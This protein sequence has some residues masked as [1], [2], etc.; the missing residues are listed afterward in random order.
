VGE[1]L[2]PTGSV[3]LLPLLAGLVLAALPQ[4]RVAVW[5]NLAA[6]TAT[7]ALACRLPWQLGARPLL[8]VDP[9]AA[10]MAILASFVGTTSAWSMAVEADAGDM[11]LRH[12]LFQVLLALTLL[13][14]LCN[15][16]GDIWICLE[17]ALLIAVVTVAM[18][19]TGEAVAAAWRYLLVGAVG[20]ALAMFGSVALYLAA[21]PAL[22]TWSSLAQTGAG[23]DVGLLN[24]AFVLLV[25]GFGA[26]AGLAP[27]HGWVPE[28]TAAG[29]APIATVFTA[30]MQL[31]PLLVVFRL[32]RVVAA[33]AEA[34]APGPLLLVLGLASLLV[35]AIGVWR[36]REA[37]RVF[38]FAG[39]A[40]SGVTLFAIGLGSAAAVFA[41]IVLLTLQT[42]TRPT[43]FPCAQH[44]RGRRL[45]LLAA[46]TA[47]AG[48]PPFGIFAGWF[49]VLNATAGTKP[50][51][52]L[53]LGAG[54]VLFA[55]ALVARLVALF[56]SAPRAERDGK[57]IVVLAPVWLQLVAGT[58]LGYAMPASLAAWFAAVASALR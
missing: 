8:L 44:L 51:L 9:P 21:R 11:R 3:V 37:K 41:G 14:L 47:M 1:F 42:L 56:P 50:W 39:I 29:V 7:F 53:P 28:V 38:A 48:L 30:G 13:A 16:L 36:E 24:V 46:V 5:L 18:P 40:Q 12:L 2:T 22:L 32:R 23:P 43:L 20:L 19:L 52:L 34:L 4:R 54:L 49:L 26:L 35:G 45:T 33:H 6:T 58:V 15:D 27:M 57:K 10:Q 25:I 55:W 17:A 31:A